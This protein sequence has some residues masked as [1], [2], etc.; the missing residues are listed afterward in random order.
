[1]FLF[2]RQSYFETNNQNSRRMNMKTKQFYFEMLMAFV[3]MMFTACSSSDEI[4]TEKGKALF[5][6]ASICAGTS[7]G[8]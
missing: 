5:L 6:D 8:E 7:N 2:L 4:I 1:M 3:A